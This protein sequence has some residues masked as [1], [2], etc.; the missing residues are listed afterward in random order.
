MFIFMGCVWFEDSQACT[1]VHHP[2]LNYPFFLCFTSFLLPSTHS[3]LLL[4]ILLSF[5]AHHHCLASR[6]SP[7]A[8]YLSFSQPLSLFSPFLSGGKWNRVTIGRHVY[9]Y[10]RKSKKK[11]KYYVSSRW[12]HHR[13][14]LQ[15]ISNCLPTFHM[16]TFKSKLPTLV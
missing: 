13:L 15:N 5:L 11:K 6:H 2:F 8:T 16:I 7:L 3:Q 14:S 12:Y 4:L 10:Q 9:C 1:T